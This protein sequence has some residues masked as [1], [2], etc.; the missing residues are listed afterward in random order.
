MA[1]VTFA[2]VS[3][4][5]FTGLK[6][7]SGLAT[8]KF[9]ASVKVSASSVPKLSVKASMKEVGIAVVATAASALLASNAMAK[10]ILLGSDDG[11]LVFVPSSFSV[12]AG[13]KLVFRNNAAYPHNVIF[14]ED[15]VPSGVD[16]NEISMKEDE[17]LNAKDEVFEVT[18]STKGDYGFYCAPHQ[19]A[20]MVGNLTV[21]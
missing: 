20:G 15:A 9:G 13:E 8:S 7:A 11:Q 4:P 18:L 3:I 17:L 10:E 2:A 1:A 14:D 5:S 21:N 19:G 6:A 16:P 12:A